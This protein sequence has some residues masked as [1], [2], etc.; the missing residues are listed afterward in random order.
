MR[1][2]IR[3]AGF[4]LTELMTVVVIIGVVAAMAV[5]FTSRKTPG[6]RGPQFARALTLAAHQAREQALSLG[7][8]TRL[9]LDKD[10]YD[11]EIVR[12]AVEKQT[13]AGAWVTLAPMLSP[14]EGVDVCEV[15]NYAVT[16]TYTP[17]CPA[18]TNARICFGPTGRVSVP[19]PADSDTCPTSSAGTGA[20]VFVRVAG[21]GSTPTVMQ[22]YKLVLFRLTGLPKL[23]EAW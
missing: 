9:R 19:S 1:A 23:L 15:V 3:Q 17:T 16:S 22:K 7:M 5:R 2:H 6:E 8:T 13:T 4:T 10:S 14:V 12:V 21:A 20:T 11:S 18:T